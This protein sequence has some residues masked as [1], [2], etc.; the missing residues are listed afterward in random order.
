MEKGHSSCEYD[1]AWIRGICLQCLVYSY[2]STVTY[3]MY[4]VYEISDLV[5]IFLLLQITRIYT[6][7]NV[8][9]LR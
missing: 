1:Y 8:V 6:D 3:V 7:D 9:P 2:W 4:S 5:S